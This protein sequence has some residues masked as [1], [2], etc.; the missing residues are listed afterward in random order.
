MENPTQLNKDIQRT[1][2]PKKEKIIT[3]EQSTHSIPILSPNPSPC[4]SGYAAGT[5]ER[6]GKTTAQGAVDIYREIIEDNIDYDILKQDAKFDSDEL[7][8]VPDLMLETAMHRQKA[9]TELQGTTTQQS[10]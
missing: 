9:G 1:D 8:E 10:L 3:D 6:N 7:D 4:G 2:L 5:H